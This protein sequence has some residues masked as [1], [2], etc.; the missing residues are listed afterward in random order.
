MN[1]GDIIKFV[2]NYNNKS[3][4]VDVPKYKKL[5][6]IKEKAYKLFYPI[7]TD[8]DIKYNNKSLSSLLE[9]SIGMIFN[10]KLFIR[11]MIISLPGVRKS[12]KIKTNK[13]ILLT[14]ETERNQ[15]QDD[16][17]DNLIVK[18]NKMEIIINNSNKLK[19]NIIKKNKSLEKFKTENNNNLNKNNINHNNKKLN[20]IKDLH[21]KKNGKK[22]LPPIKTENNKNKIDIIAYNNCSECI[23]NITSEYCRKCNKFLCLSCS[24][25]NHS[26]EDH[27]LIEIEE[28]KEKTNISRYK[29]EINKD[30]YNYFK[31]HN[32][33]VFRKGKS[34]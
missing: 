31:Y 33:S 8:I 19:P 4:S 29:E 6:Y 15:N 25:E 26:K 27:K 10:N 18:N 20:N 24:N 34:N 30:L 12:M 2:L 32:A 11:L 28:D 16:N 22:K 13:S 23:K 21:L 17:D 3:L 9:Q 7:K 1:N 14:L 5:K